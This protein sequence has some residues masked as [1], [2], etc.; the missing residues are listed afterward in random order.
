MFIISHCC[1][2]YV[3]VK[4]ARERLLFLMSVQEQFS[5]SL[6]KVFS[7]CRALTAKYLQPTFPFSTQRDVIKKPLALLSLF[8]LQ[9]KVKSY[10]LPWLLTSLYATCIWHQC[11]QNLI[12]TPHFQQACCWPTA[13]INLQPPV[14]QMLPAILH[15]WLCPPLLKL[16]NNDVTA[17]S[18]CS[19]E[20]HMNSHSRNQIRLGP[21]MAVAQSKLKNWK[22]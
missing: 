14:S 12:M 20:S 13:K 18:A 1:S 9:M 10:L 15:I 22:D 5:E 3:V 11:E 7:F 17:M 16:M 6:S 21:H 2:L 8:T 4:S 19:L